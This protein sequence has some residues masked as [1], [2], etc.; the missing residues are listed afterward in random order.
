MGRRDSSPL[1]LL[2]LLRLTPAIGTKVELGDAAEA[3]KVPRARMASR[4]ELPWRGD[5]AIMAACGLGAAWTDS[6]VAA[7]SAST[8]LVGFGGQEP[9][10]GAGHGESIDDA[11][12]WLRTSSLLRFSGEASAKPGSSLDFPETASL[13]ER[14]LP[15]SKAGAAASQDGAATCDSRMPGIC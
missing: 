1:P 5:R 9:S 8:G 2:L 14:C 3:P 4:R 15:G 13:P 11:E 6:T 10:R 7:A 12:G